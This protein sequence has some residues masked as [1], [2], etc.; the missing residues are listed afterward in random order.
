MFLFESLLQN[1]PFN[2]DFFP[3]DACLV[4]GAVRDILL[5]RTKDYFDLDFV[6]PESSVVIAKKLANKYQAGFV[7]L[8]AERDICRVVFSSGTVDI[9]RQE[10]DVLVKD[11]QRRDFT[12]NAIAYNFSSQQLID[13]LLGLEDLE[14]KVIRAISF[15]NLQD[16]PLR[17]LR[18]YRQA[19]QLNFSLA[20]ETREMIRTLAPLITTMA[21]ERVRVE[22]NYLFANNLGSQWLFT[23]WQDGLIEPWFENL[24]ADKLDKVA[25]IDRIA[26]LLPEL[27]DCFPNLITIAKLAILVDRDPITAERQLIDLKYSR[28][29]IKAVLA[30]I[31]NLP[32]L[33]GRKTPL[34]VQEQYFLFLEV[35]EFFPILA[36][37]GINL[38]INREIIDPLIARYLDS[39][40]RLAHPQ[41]LINGNDLIE[42]L[43]LKPSPLIGRLLTQIQLAYI[44]ERISNREQALKLAFD[45]LKE[46]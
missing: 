6:V 7:V 41:A 19:A 23:A 14:K 37:L 5:G 40:D 36:L 4:G 10:G 1:L 31:K 43:K 18:A 12:I 13:P 39:G 38:G 45:L 34:N 11:L 46:N 32:Q 15:K 26:T 20:I 21:T 25:T 24:N 2:L 22:L 16:D 27:N 29:E 30:A 28:A 44:E 3:R 42:R 17:L 33:E 35:G 9:A 8:D